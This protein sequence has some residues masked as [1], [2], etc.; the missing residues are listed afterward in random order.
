[1]VRLVASLDQGQVPF[2]LIK[3]L[4]LDVILKDHQQRH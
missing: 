2:Q 1:M 4:E 3:L